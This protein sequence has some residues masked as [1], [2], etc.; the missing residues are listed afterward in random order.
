MLY[1]VVVYFFLKH[2]FINQWIK[3][4][5]YICIEFYNMQTNYTRKMIATYRYNLPNN[6]F[7][8]LWHIIT[9]C[10]YNQESHGYGNIGMLSFF[11]FAKDSTII[12]HFDH[13][14][15]VHYFGWHCTC[16][17]RKHLNGIQNVWILTVEF[18]SSYSHPFLVKEPGLFMIWIGDC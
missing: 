3:C 4:G 10:F 18:V 17:K 15:S 8:F 2:C 7:Q 6:L 13:E 16:Y 11:E 1:L 14:F 12:F 5:S 9:L